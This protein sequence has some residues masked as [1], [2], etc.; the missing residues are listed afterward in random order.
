MINQKSKK[1]KGYI[2]I[3]AGD[4]AREVTVVLQNSTSWDRG[5]H[6]LAYYT[7]VG[8]IA[9]ELSEIKVCRNMK[10]VQNYCP[11]DCWM[12]ICGVGSPKYRAI[13]FHKFKEVGYSFASI[14][15]PLATVESSAQIGEGCVI[16]SG[17]RVAIG[18]YIGDNVLINYNAVIGHDTIIGNHSIIS[19]GAN[20]GGRITGGK[21]VYYGIGSSVLQ[22]K[23]IG[24]RATLS[25][26]C[27]VWFDVS[28]YTTV[29]GTPAKKMNI[30]G[31]K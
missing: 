13:L 12:A 24:N 7:D 23:K 11:P 5:K 29:G 4:L 3:G 17:A 18:C 19:P 21:E 16:F 31:K 9:A 8:V 2:I 26:G 30:P 28:S 15:S 10:E 14:L 22:G 25:A 6:K 27:S 20:L 1:I